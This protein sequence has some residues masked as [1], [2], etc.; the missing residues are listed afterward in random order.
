MA[1]TLTLN[2]QDEKND[3]LPVP[4]GIKRC[5]VLEQVAP[6]FLIPLLKPS[7]AREYH[8]RSEV[9]WCGRSRSTFYGWVVS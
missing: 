9:A 8:A 2:D 6:V 1:G 7:N 4:V 5:A 3:N